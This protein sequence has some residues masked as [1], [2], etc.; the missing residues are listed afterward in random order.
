MALSFNSDGG[1]SGQGALGLIVL[2]TD[3]TL[4]PEINPI[5]AAAG[6]PLYHAR[7]PSDPEVTKETLKQMETD[8]PATAA[9][10]PKT[11]PFKALGYG[12]TSGATVIGP[13]Q[14]SSLV[15]QSLPGVAVTNPLSAVIAACRCFQAKRIGF[16]TPYI[17]EV[18]DL[19][20][21]RL[22]EAGIGVNALASFEQIEDAAVARIA[23]ASVRDALIDLAPGC[24]LMFVSC[25]NLRSFSIIEEVEGR[26]NIPVISSNS[27]MIWHMLRLSGHKG[28]LSG[29]GRLF[30]QEQSVS[31]TAFRN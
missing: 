26:I 10:L 6:L 3:E 22:E 23:T 24:D 30:E 1:H 15:Q 4:E 18:S 14:V 19:M 5:A 8:L 12:C 2:S 20:R 16:L 25:T 7:I 13:E 21:Q 29:P 28:P 17:A 27:A 31:P 9:L 11:A